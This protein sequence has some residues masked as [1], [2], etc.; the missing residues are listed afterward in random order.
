[1]EEAKNDHHESKKDAGDV[2]RNEIFHG[3]IVVVISNLQ[4]NW[5]IHKQ[6]FNIKGPLL[7]HTFVTY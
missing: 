6:K 2:G 3:C 5:P 7:C 1:M 4:N